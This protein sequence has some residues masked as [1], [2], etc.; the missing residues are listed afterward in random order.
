MTI[1]YVEDDPSDREFFKEAINAIAPRSACHVVNDASEALDYLN[2]TKANP[3]L[4]FLDINLPGMN[5]IVF[6]ESIKSNP[7]MKN[8][9]VIMFSTSVSPV[10]KDEC[11]RL[12][13]NG[14]VAKQNTFKEICEVL[15]KF[16]SRK[17]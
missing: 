17:K 10:D 12:G 11:L 14:F 5:G 16:V 4:I 3:D 7:Q 2:E 8:I 9:K 13:A 15:L 6:L 1:L